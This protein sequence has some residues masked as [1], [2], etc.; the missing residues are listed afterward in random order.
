MDMDGLVDDKNLDLVNVRNKENPEQALPTQVVDVNISNKDHGDGVEDIE[1][2]SVMNAD[3]VN[4][5]KPEQVLTSQVA[6]MVSMNEVNEDV[7]VTMN[8]VDEEGLVVLAMLDTIKKGDVGNEPSLDKTNQ[9]EGEGGREIKKV[10]LNKVKTTDQTGCDGDTIRAVQKTG[11]S[12]EG[13]KAKEVTGDACDNEDAG[14]D[15]DE[16]EKY[17][18]DRDAEWVSKDEVEN[19]REE[20]VELED[21]S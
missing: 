7:D 21:A 1:N 13:D 17:I 8:N 20:E 4:K 19:I 12:R 18:E 16:D 3:N 10:K 11:N 2:M 5:G 14:G 6:G 9:G 15:E